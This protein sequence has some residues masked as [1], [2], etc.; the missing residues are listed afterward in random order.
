ML[1]TMIIIISDQLVENNNNNT[2]I[3]SRGSSAY[4][5]YY[6]HYYYYEYFV[7]EGGRQS[8]DCPG[9]PALLASSSQFCKKGDVGRDE[10]LISTSVEVR[11]DEVEEECYCCKYYLETVKVRGV[12]TR[13]IIHTFILYKFSMI[14]R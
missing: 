6:C 9:F 5:N 14:Y 7:P 1:A 10:N 3:V 4:S 12:L 2:G 13:K 11:E 8:L